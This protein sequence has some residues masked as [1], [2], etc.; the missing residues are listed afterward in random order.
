MREKSGND[1]MSSVLELKVW[2][3][4]GLWCG[5]LVIRIFKYPKAE[6]NSSTTRPQPFSTLDTF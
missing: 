6:I 5:N 4:D 3:S 1:I 2:S